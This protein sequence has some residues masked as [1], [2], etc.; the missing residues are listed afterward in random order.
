MITDTCQRYTEGRETRR[1]AGEIIRPSAYDAVAIDPASAVAFV[2]RHH[3][4]ASCSTRRI[5]KNGEDKAIVV[6]DIQRGQIESARIAFLDLSEQSATVEPV[7]PVV[8]AQRFAD[9]DI[10]AESEARAA[11]ERQAIPKLDLGDDS[12]PGAV[13]AKSVNVPA[14]ELA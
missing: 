4:A 12:E 10:D 3:Y 11:T 13:V 8:N 6:A 9:L 14:M 1:P 7:L 2:E 5:E